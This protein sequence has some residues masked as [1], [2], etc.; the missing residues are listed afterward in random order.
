M[1]RDCAIDA[2]DFAFE[3]NRDAPSLGI[4][5]IGGEPMLCYDLI[6]EVVEHARYRAT[7]C[8][9]QV[10]FDLTTN[11]VLL[12]A[13]HARYFRD[14]GLR[15][16]LS[17]DGARADHDRYRP[18]RGGGGS[19]ETVAKKMHMLK[20]FQPW[21]GARMTV[22]PEMA[23]HLCTNVKHLH[24]ELA[25]NQFVIASATNTKWPDRD[26]A[27]YN[28]SLKELFEYYMRRLSG[29]SHRRLR[30]GL[31]EV[32]SVSVTPAAGGS[33][34]WGCGAG[35]GRLAVSPDGMFSGCS[36]LSWGRTGWK[37][38]PLPLGNVAT[39]FDPGPSRQ[40][41]LDHSLAARRKC[42]SCELRNSC[43]GGCY[44]ANYVDSGDIYEPSDS[45]C[46]LMLAQKDAADYGRKRLREL[47]LERLSDLSPP[48]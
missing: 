19:F 1:E 22:M 47:G 45:F 26:V 15:Y 34:A 9:K 6:R 27:A 16:L 23:A 17:L 41:L 31:L 46:K 14:V 37:D 2:V 18:K 43:S 25:I 38:A 4:S 40:L 8:E 30:I 20:G 32:G 36:K 10:G 28:L 5:F 3:Q 48:T 12:T 42:S 24:E 33:E 11:G 29:E 35:S 13:R 39:G 44:A 7:A 21:Q